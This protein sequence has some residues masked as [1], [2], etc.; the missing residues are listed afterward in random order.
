MTLLLQ[1]WREKHERDMLLN[2]YI[3]VYIYFGNVMY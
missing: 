3:S 2:Q 1:N